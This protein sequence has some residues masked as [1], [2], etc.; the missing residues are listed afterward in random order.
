MGKHSNYRAIEG[1]PN[2]YKTSSGKITFRKRFPSFGQKTIPTGTDSIKEAKK[3]VENKLIDLMASDPKAEKRKRSGITNPLLRDLWPEMV[4]D[5]APKKAKHT[6]ENY[7]TSWKYSIEPFW[8]DLTVSQV[9]HQMVTKFENWYLKNRGDKA[10]YNVHKHLGMF[11]RYL[12]KHKFIDDVPKLEQLEETIIKNTKRK[13][14]GRV[15]SDD[16]ITAL[17]ENAVNDRTR[18]CIKVYRNLGPRKMELLSSELSHW[19][20][21]KTE[22]KFWSAKNQ[23]W[24]TVPIPPNILSEVKAWIDKRIKSKDKSPF[25]F[26]ADVN[27]QTHI[28]SQVFDRDWL[29]TKRLANISEWNIK[30]AARVHDLRHTFAT[31]TAND[32]WPVMHACFVLD[33]TPKEY[34]RTYVHIRAVDVRSLMRKSFGEKP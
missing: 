19:D 24:R 5:R 27:K 1:H 8:G 4:E 26:P 14:V 30:N 16:E 10:Y 12:R 32:S 15:Y 11:F 33:M 22:V 13:K 17:V 23:E 34:H 28:S 2:Y 29:E 6:L 31:Q 3:I 20:I 21:K 9:T 7:S 18:V 25:M